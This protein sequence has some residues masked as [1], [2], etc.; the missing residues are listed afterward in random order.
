MGRPGGVNKQ[1][2]SPA[3]EQVVALAGLLTSFREA[4]ERVLKVMSGMKVSA[5]T[6]QRTTEKAGERY[7]NQLE[8][9]QQEG[10]KEQWQWHRDAQGRRC[11][12]VSVDATAV[13]QQGP[14]GKRAEG[15]M[16][17]VAMVYNPGGKAQGKRSQV[18][19]VAGLYDLPTLGRLLHEQALQVGWANADKQIA[20][21][22]GGAGLE[23]FFR[24]YFP[25]AECILDFWHA[26]E[27]LVQLGQVLY[28][29]DEQKRIGWT[30]YASGKLKREGGRA[31][32]CWLERMDLSGATAEQKEEHRRQVQYFRNHEHKMDYPRYLANGWQIGSGPVESACKTVIGNRLKGGGMRWGEREAHVM[33]NLRALFLSEPTCW[34]TFW[35]PPPAQTYLQN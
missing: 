16:A 32:R 35:H 2:L 8:E 25:R 9:G 34:T 12:Y 18:R 31:V 14:G 1:E 20:I 23:N 6:V 4:S 3:A 7:C 22:D 33:C 24:T 5:A 13:R 29:E 21:S 30:E 27:H 26:R 19:Y 15:R 10:P 28:P 11:A 17:Y